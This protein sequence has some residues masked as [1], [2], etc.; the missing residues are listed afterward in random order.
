LQRG[1]CNER[2][3]AAF[4]WLAAGCGARGSRLFDVDRCS[5]EMEK[6][7]GSGLLRLFAAVGTLLLVPRA[8][9]ELLSQ[10]IDIYD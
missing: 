6:P 5:V 4:F 8:L 7:A 2:D 3:S 9:I 1:R 10:V